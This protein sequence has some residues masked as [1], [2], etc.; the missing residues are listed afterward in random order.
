MVRKSHRDESLVKPITTHEL[1]PV[2]TELFFIVQA[3]SPEWDYA[4]Y[5]IRRV[6]QTETT[7][8]AV[9]MMV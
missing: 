5:E 1:S 2:G 4:L 6:L 3:E 9:T 7:A 8:S